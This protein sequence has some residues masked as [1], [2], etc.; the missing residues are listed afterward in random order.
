[1]KALAKKALQKQKLLLAEMQ[2]RQMT[3]FS[4]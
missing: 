2:Q 1:M 4:V 3:Y